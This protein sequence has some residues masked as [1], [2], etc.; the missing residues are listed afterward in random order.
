[1]VTAML[2]IPMQELSCILLNRPLR[3]LIHRYLAIISPLTFP[4]NN[5]MLG[6]GI[7]LSIPDGRNFIRSRD[8][9]HTVAKLLRGITFRFTMQLLTT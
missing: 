9:E 8:T 6:T 2:C 4:M 3:L 5:S 1:M 7:T